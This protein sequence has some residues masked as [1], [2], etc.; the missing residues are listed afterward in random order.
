VVS[1]HA[2]KHPEA[3]V[4]IRIGLHTGEALR[5][6]DDFYGKAV[7]LAARIAAAA[8]GGQILVSALLKEITE[9]GGDFTYV[10]EREMELKG[11][12]GTYRVFEV[13]WS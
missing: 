11:L 10:H 9:S 1:E 3:L 2:E 13:E 4:R 5:D 7:V 12:S 6:K 8:I